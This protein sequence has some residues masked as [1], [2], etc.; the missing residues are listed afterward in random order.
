[1]I[2]K[3]KEH[4]LDYLA[5]NYFDIDWNKREGK[6]NF[7][8]TLTDREKINNFS[9]GN[10]RQIN[11]DFL[12]V[13]VKSVSGDRSDGFGQLGTVN[14]GT[15]I[16]INIY[17]EK[18]VKPSDCAYLSDLYMGILYDRMQQFDY[19]YREGL[20]PVNPSLSIN[21]YYSSS[22]NSQINFNSIDKLIIDCDY[23]FTYKAQ[24]LELEDE[25]D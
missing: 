17:I 10:L 8:K 20:T 5:D 2:E 13:Q 14:F 11:K 4:I 24:H 3:I 7:N 15:T 22:N 16:T 1:M 12:L 21:K 9:L 25:N 23:T 19:N 18:D 6:G